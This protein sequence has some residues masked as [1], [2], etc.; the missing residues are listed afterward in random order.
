MTD[1]PSDKTEGKPP[2]E[3]KDNAAPAADGASPASRGRGGARPGAGRKPLEGAR[4]DTAVLVRMNRGQKEAFRTLG[5]SRWLR[6]R[7][8]AERIMTFAAASPALAYPPEDASRIIVLSPDKARLSF[9]DWPSLLAALSQSQ[10]SKAADGAWQ[11]AREAILNARFFALIVKSSALAPAQGAAP[12]MD[13]SQKS[14]EPLTVLIIEKAESPALEG[15][16]AEADAGSSANPVLAEKGDDFLLASA[17][18]IREAAKRQ[19]EGEEESV[20]AV[21]LLGRVR[22]VTSLR[23]L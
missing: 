8:N 17:Q 5:G 6:E 2:A 4:Y 7:L 9:A 18:A 14:K 15:A 16:R 3:I 12:E 22:A 20:S 11:D 19:A 1:L 21:R 13:E 23:L 10:N